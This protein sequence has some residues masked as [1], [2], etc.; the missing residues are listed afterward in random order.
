MRLPAGIA[1]VRRSAAEYLFGRV[2]LAMRSRASRATGAGAGADSR[3]IF[4]NWRRRCAQQKASV[5]DRASARVSRV[6]VL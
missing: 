1:L 6:M 2:K 4:T 5:P 3:S